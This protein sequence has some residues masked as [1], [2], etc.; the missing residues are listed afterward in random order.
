MLHTGEKQVS[1]GGSIRGI[2]IGLRSQ[3]YREILEN[4]PSVP[5]FEVLTDNYLGEGGQPLVYLERVRAEYPVTFHGVGMSLGSCEP[6]NLD[7]LGKV[8]ALAQRI[9]PAWISDHL[10]WS[11]SGGHYSH[12]LLPLPY[13]KEA[14]RH[15]A[16][17]IAQAQDVLGCRLV[18]ENV[19]G[20]VSFADSEMSEW[21]FLVAVVEQADCD[22]LLDINNIYVSACNHGFDAEHYLN[23][24]PKQRVR[25]MHLAGYEDQGTHLLD[26]H[27]LPVHEPVWRLYEKALRR[28][29]QVPTLIE[30]DTDIP[31]FHCLLQEADKARYI[32][33]KT[34]GL[35]A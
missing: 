13:T 15:M 1:G 32:F 9:Q 28:L 11:A 33:E 31:P 27:G 18:V 22:I 16:T 8:K 30:W 20:Y 4:L 25:E 6:L 19:S 3:H 24:I 34:S 12:D 10:C 7:Y 29:D 26:T 14:I 2:G 35:P 21:E 23:A 17:R 5:W